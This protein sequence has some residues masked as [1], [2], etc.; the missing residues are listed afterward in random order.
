MAPPVRARRTIAIV[1]SLG[2]DGRRLG[3]G[4]VAFG[5]VGLALAVVVAVALVLGGFAVR[6]MGDELEASRVALA[7]SMSRASTSVGSAALA[8]ANMRATLESTEA[9][10]TRTG[11]T[12]ADVADAL[13][14]LVGA[15]D[16]SILGQQPLAG[17]A[18]AFAGLADSMRGY[19]DDVDAIAVDLRS[20]Q[21]DLDD[22]TADLRDLQRRID[23]L[24][25]RVEAFDRVDEIVAIASFGLLLVG[26][27]T[28]WI[29]IGG[30][31]V[32]WLGWRLRRASGGGARSG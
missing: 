22:M 32:A 30:G 29:A 11:E 15:L 21:Q 8:T 18:D 1:E 5:L 19:A 13:D 12:L 24:A 10:L 17:A 28:A 7:D 4:L 20:N 27:L 6:S 23:D 9:A 2:T 16:F 14:A 3:G 26:A 31:L 25:E